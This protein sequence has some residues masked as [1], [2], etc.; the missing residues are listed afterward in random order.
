MAFVLSCEWWMRPV[1]N[2]STTSYYYLIYCTVSL[3]REYPWSSALTCAFTKGL[4]ASSISFFA[5][6]FTSAHQP[7]Q[8]PRQIAQIPRLDRIKV[9]ACGLS[10]DLLQ[11]LPEYN[12]DAIRG[13]LLNRAA[14]DEHYSV[15]CDVEKAPVAVD[16][17]VCI[18]F[19]RIQRLLNPTSWKPSTP[20]K[21]QRIDSYDH[22]PIPTS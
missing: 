18:K 8:C 6:Q 11:R 21:T 22:W 12:F 10:H 7:I 1:Q 5:I 20:S 9:P 4:F 14:S 16:M 13:V 17:R 3:P 2:A 15:Q 19:N